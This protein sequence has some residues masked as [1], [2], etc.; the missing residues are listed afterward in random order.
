MKPWR[1][2]ILGAGQMAQ[3]FD[4]PGSPRVLSMAHAFTRSDRFTIGGFF[5]TNIDRAVAA[6]RKWDVPE[7][8]RERRSWLDAGWDAFYVATPDAD[9]ATDLSDILRRTPRGVLVEKPI[10]LD[11]KAGLALLTSAHDQ[12]VPLMVNF[13]RRWHSGV[14][15][16]RAMTEA[17][18]LSPPTAAF[19][20]ISGA[21][22]HNLPHAIDLI[23]SIWDG[24]WTVQRDGVKSAGV[25]RITL[26]RGD[27]SCAMAIAE[28]PRS[29]YVWEMH[30]YCAEGK[31]EFSHSPEVL[32]WSAPAPHPH[33]PDY[34]VLTAV[35]RC[36]MEGEPLLDR[37]VSALAEAMEDSSVASRIFDRE[38]GSQQLSAQVLQWC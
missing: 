20:V 32:E 33:Y 35:F 13:P 11:G 23:H 34:N 29:P 31:A 38:I 15:R 2:G 30:L 37:A 7:S 18:Q 25:T 17:G 16:L 28:R 5:D 36:D 6:E 27:A 12:G 8:P 24:G 19:V 21:P 4:H 9:H 3:G 26:C 10:A 1:V 14:S 22:M